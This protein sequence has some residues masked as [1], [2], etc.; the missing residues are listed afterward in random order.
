MSGAL[1]KWLYLQ[2]AFVCKCEKKLCCTKLKNEFKILGEYMFMKKYLTLIALPVLLIAGCTVEKQNTAGSLSTSD[3]HIGQAKIVYL[4]SSR[5]PVTAKHI[6][7][8]EKSGAPKMCTIDRKDVKIHR[9]ESLAGYLTK[10][11]Y[12]RDEFP[13]AMCKEG[14]YHANIMYVPASDNR[15]A[16]AWISHQL[17]GLPDGTAVEILVK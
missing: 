6:L 3:T 5:Y 12:D 7:A 17:R 13:M 16:G 1:H 2:T 10:P 11:G 14:G 15:G 9:K 8:A 4:P